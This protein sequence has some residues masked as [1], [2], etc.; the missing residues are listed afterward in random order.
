MSIFFSFEQVVDI[1]FDVNDSH[2]AKSPR[3]FIVIVWKWK[4]EK[5]KI[6]IS[7]KF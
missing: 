4:N 5:S 7:N 6:I 2:V 3:I 1:H